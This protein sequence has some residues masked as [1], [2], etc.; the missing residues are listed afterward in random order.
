[1]SRDWGL[2]KRLP[3]AWSGEPSTDPFVSLP[4]A[5]PTYRDDPKN[6]FRVRPPLS[7]PSSLGV[8]TPLASRLG[9]RP[10]RPLEDST[11]L[12]RLGSKEYD[13]GRAV[14]MQRPIN[15]TPFL[16]TSRRVWFA[17]PLGTTMAQVWRDSP[18]AQLTPDGASPFESFPDMVFVSV[19]AG[20]G[21]FASEEGLPSLALRRDTSTGWGR[22][23]ASGGF[24]HP[25]GLRRFVGQH[26]PVNLRGKARSKMESGRGSIRRRAGCRLDRA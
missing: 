2:H 5:A 23:S 20:V 13:G 17:S 10:R 16:P 19:S 15:R 21:S 3:M 25:L 11:P 8:L 12:R 18:G 9:F 4:P 7:I 24:S 6:P 1:M 22:G 26:L 14:S